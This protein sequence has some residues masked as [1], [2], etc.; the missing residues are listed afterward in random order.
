M[1]F[2][3]GVQG[4]CKARRHRIII[5]PRPAAGG[6]V[7]RSPAARP[8][9]RGSC[10]VSDPSTAARRAEAAAWCQ[11]QKEELIVGVR[12][13][14]KPGITFPLRQFGDVCQLAL[15][16]AVA[17]GAEPLIT[18]L[19]PSEITG[20][21]SV[22]EALRQVRLL[23]DWLA[24]SAAVDTPTAHGEEWIPFGSALERAE[25]AGLPVSR[26]QLSKLVSAGKVA[27][28]PGPPPGTR[29]LIG[30]N[31]LAGHL[32]RAKAEKKRAGK[33][34]R[35]QEGDKES[36]ADAKSQKKSRNIMDWNPPS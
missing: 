3:Q 22:A 7:K 14:G 26:G 4:A 30:W 6:E 12:A 19:G 11:A 34:E 33:D 8:L 16:Y 35:E 29:K 9:H 18:D 27:S 21:A 5:D 2:P 28:Q 15:D 23:A 10:N 1:K 31:S 25:Q 13:M 24:S 20:E 36:I 17:L 32:A